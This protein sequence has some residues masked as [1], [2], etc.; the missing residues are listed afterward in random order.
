MSCIRPQ[1]VS[2]KQISLI[3]YE[4]ILSNYSKH[5]RIDLLLGEQSSQSLIKLPFTVIQ[6]PP[7]DKLLEEPVEKIDYGDSVR[8]PC[9]FQG[10]GQ[11]IVPRELYVQQEKTL[12][13][14]KTEEIINM[15]DLQSRVASVE[16]KLENGRSIRAE[17]IDS[18]I[19]V[20][21]LAGFSTSCFFVN[22]ERPYQIVA[23]FVATAIGA[24]AGYRTA[25]ET[26]EEHR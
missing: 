23:A 17:A 13:K 20:A 25:L 3:L 10:I 9:V 22:Y 6:E 11:I 7:K 5:E 24:W 8:I 2:E 16:S 26:E 1:Q 18:S 4:D 19:K 21:I 12:S 14:V 15:E